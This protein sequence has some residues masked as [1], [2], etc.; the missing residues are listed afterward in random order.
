MIVFLFYDILLNTLCRS[1]IHPLFITGALI[2]DRS[3]NRPRLPSVTVLPSHFI[4]RLEDTNV[5]WIK[6]YSRRN[7]L[8]T[9][10]LVFFPFCHQVGR[11]RGGG[12]GGGGC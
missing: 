3:K 7:D 2:R 11:G 6:S 8:F 5:E 12:G 4:R 9:Y 1:N 10:D